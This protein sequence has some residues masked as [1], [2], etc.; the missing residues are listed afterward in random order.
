MGLRRTI[1][2]G[3]IANSLLVVLIIGI[4]D[5]YG[6]PDNPFLIIFQISSINFMSALVAV[7]LSPSPSNK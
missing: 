7:I 1:V 3:M 4:W 5:I 6:M 2:Q